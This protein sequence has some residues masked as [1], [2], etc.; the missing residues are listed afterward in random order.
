[1]KKIF[2]FLTLTLCLLFTAMGVNA[3]NVTVNPG[4]GS[5]PTL[6][7]AF[8]AINAGTHTGAV[9]VTIINSTTEAA[10]CVLNSSG[11]GS[12]SY[13]SVSIRPS[14]DN[15]VVSGPTVTGRGLIE[16][17]GADNV[18]INGDNPNSGGT[19][20]NLTI[21]NTAANTVTF[22]SCI[23]TATSTLITNVDNNSVVNCILAGS[24]TGR[25]VSTFTT[26]VV[27]WGI[28]VSGNAS[29]LSN[30]TA[31]SALTSATSTMASGQTA[32]N[33][34]ISNNNIV[35]V[36]RGVSINGAATTVAPSLLISSNVIGNPT[37]GS[38][39]QVTQNGITVS[40][41]DN[42]SITANTVYAESFHTTNSATRGIEVGVISVNT[43]AANI[44]NNIIARIRNNNTTTYGAYGINLNGGNNHSVINNAVM[45][46]TNDQTAGTGAFSTTFG[47]H[48]I[49]IGTGTGHKIYHNSVNLAGVIPG[50]ISTDLISCFTIVGTTQTGCDV[51]N[52]I[53]SNT[54]SGGNPT[55]NSV[56]FVSIYL[57]SGGTS[58]MNLTLNNNAYYQGNLANSGI[59]QVSS[60]GSAA[61][62][63]LSSNFAPGVITPSTNLRAY[64]SLLSAAG[65]NDNASIA[66]SSA[67]PFTSATDLHIPFATP[68]PLES[69]GAFVGVTVDID[70]NVRPG[71]AGSVNGGA[72][73]P[74]LG[75][76]EFDGVP[77]GDITPPVISYTALT[78]TA[79]VSNRSFT[80]V[81][82]TDVSGV[83]GTAGTRPRVYYKRSSDAN[84]YVDNTSGSNGWKY[85]EATGSTSP[86]D[87]TIN[88]ALL[89]GGGGVAV[90]NTV[91]YFVVAQD[92]AGT[93]NVGI[94]SGVFAAQP[95]SVALTSGAFPLTGAI[96]SYII[97]G[98]PLAGDYTV[99]VLLFN[100]IT[101]KNITFR[102]EVAKVKKEVNVPVNNDN[103]PSKSERAPEMTSMNSDGETVMH[104][105]D[106]VVYVPYSNGERYTGELFASREEYPNLP[107]DAGAGVFATVSDAVTSLNINGSS[108]AVRFLLLDATY[109][110]ETLPITINYATASSV[111]TLT[112]QPN[113][114][115][116]SSITG[117]SAANA[118]FRILS[119]YVTI[120]GSNNGTVTRD[121]TITNTSI[122][123]PSVVL[124]GSTGVTPITNVSLKNCN[125]VNGVNTSTAVV[126]SDA[127]VAGTAG[128]FNNITIQN[129]SIRK[130]YMGIYNIAVVGAGNGTGLSI[131]ANDFST[132]G[133]DAIRYIGV[134]VQGVDG[135][136]VSS[137]TMANFDGVS[138]ED[139]KG[140]WFATGS[141]NCT[142]NGNYI[143][144][145]V[146]TGTGGYGGQGI[147]VSTATANANMTISNNMI[148]N[149]SGDGWSYSSIPTDN[150]IGIS[151]YGTAQS[152]I[153]VYYNSINMYGNTLNK[154][155]AMSMGVYLA[156]ASSADIRDNSIVNN[157]GLLAA[158]GYGTVGVYVVTDNTQLTNSNYNNYLVGATGSGINLVGR[159]AAAGSATLAD[160][161]TATAQDVNSISGDP[162]Y[163]SN[164][165]LHITAG[166]PLIS[167]GTPIA[168]ITTDIDGQTRNVT[169][170]TIG[171]DEPAATQTLSLRFN[172]ES[173]PSAGAV[174]V[175]LRSSNSPYNLVQS[176]SS[177]A[178]GNVF[179]N[180][181][182]SSAVNGVGY[183]LVV[184]SA[185][186]VETWSAAPITFTAG[187]AS[188]NF[189]S[190]LSQAYAN[191]QKLSGGIPSVFQGDA[192][193]DGFV[194][195]TDI[196]AV[197]NN[198]ITFTNAPST[199]F[200]CDGITD[201]SDII[202][203]TNNSSAFVQV[204]KP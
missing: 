125:I 41:C 67:A 111:N 62:L 136:N 194:N 187:S 58:T 186:M 21:Q 138:A 84:T 23:R 176:V 198:A 37:A 110:S 142:A 150:P 127:A 189:A 177:T 93:P 2:S 106:E 155:D 73:A 137:N 72:T 140:I 28:I 25:N 7:A 144:D 36:S 120:Q 134:Y 9:T 103:N 193:Q 99:G 202:V 89:S 179:N 199:D 70:G 77:G 157:L 160:W 17:N 121:L 145:L 146:Y 26:E 119:S 32:A 100:S 182:F 135:A 53:F 124:V 6:Q 82:V 8:D 178:G 38:V 57:P 22:T 204:Q 174:T 117:A 167:A 116:T 20:R 107:L 96:N 60:T 131:N 108:A 10:P 31:P 132:S 123:T 185:N 129:N 42:S 92:L 87:F 180:V 51:R 61:N 154:T 165:D 66:A 98:P 47:V 91:Q 85:A 97:S 54:T 122:T 29:T 143:H 55:V 50:A 95:S 27:T 115:V 184:K 56:V 159:I 118:V 16:L 128:Y 113:S 59:A 148:A 141:T 156:A 158:L 175:E 65:T 101:G 161:K 40:G 114:S 151:I 1:M 90:N 35:T 112:I 94:N 81:T 14:N 64:T 78:N 171:A 153:K 45:G 166:S 75:Y 126:V 195:S 24:G 5:Y 49:R 170:P 13:T 71:P 76:D 63:Y 173:C 18:T 12:A 88:Y 34:I 69:G 169:T 83:N 168:G 203:A 190:A 86:F 163:V 200:N 183:Y 109:A 164:T 191:N 104:E 172:F 162:L 149:L 133:A 80:N 52:N 196:L 74:D 68:G 33:M 4:G 197:Y 105:V 201:V 48:G 46:C 152:G 3:Q 43:T 181:V 79:S 11:A 147:A 192:N 102:Q 15:V 44:T 30:T 19:N 188:Y 130:A 39:D 139:D